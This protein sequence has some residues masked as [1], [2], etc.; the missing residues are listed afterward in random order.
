MNEQYAE[1]LVKAKA[2][3]KF[4]LIRVLL[5]LAIIVAVFLVLF[6]GIMLI[7]PIGAIIIVGAIYLF[8]RFSNMEYE[9]IYCSGQLDFDRITGGTKRKTVLRVDM[10][11]V[12]IVARP[13]S[14]FL[15]GAGNAAETKDFTSGDKSRIY[16]MMADVKEKRIRILFEPTEK[17]LE[18]MYYKAP[19]KVKRS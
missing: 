7:A 8:P 16:V 14:S 10:E 19:S 11:N 5:I 1:A 12:E 2:S 6:S 9:I 18:G 4:I 3:P 17:M 13:G 15:D